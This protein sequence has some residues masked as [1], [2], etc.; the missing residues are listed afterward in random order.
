MFGKK[1]KRAITLIELVVVIA[2]IAILAGVS[3]TVFIGVTNKARTNADKEI[4]SQL[5]DK[6]RAKKI[7]EGSNKTAHDAY[8]DAKEIGF[9]LEAIKSQ[10]GGQYVWDETNDLFACVKL[11]E[12]GKTLGE[13]IAEDE[14][15]PFSSEKLEKAWIF[16]NEVK[17]DAQYSQY[18]NKACDKEE[19][20]VIAGF[21]GGE[22][23]HVKKVTYSGSEDVVIRTATFSTELNVQSGTVNHYGYSGIVKVNSGSLNE[24]GVVGRLL[25]S[26]SV[27]DTAKVFFKNGG[28]DPE[29]TC[30]HTSTKIIVDGFYVYEVCTNCGHALVD[31][32]DYNNEGSNVNVRVKDEIRPLA[33]YEV[34]EVK[35]EEEKNCISLKADSNALLDPVKFT[36]DKKAMTCDHNFGS[37]KVDAKCLEN[38]KNSHE[39][40]LCHLEYAEVIPQFGHKW[41]EP[42]YIWDFDEEHYQDAKCVALATCKHDSDHEISEKVQ[43]G[44]GIVYQQTKEA[45]CTEGSKGTLTATFKK[46]PFAGK[47]ASVPCD[48][49]V[50]AKGHTF[51]EQGECIVCHLSVKDVFESGEGTALDPYVIKKENF[52]DFS[53]YTNGTSTEDKFFELEDDVV[54]PEEQL[55]PIGTSSFPF[56]G[57]FDGN[58]KTVSNLSLEQP[59]YATDNSKKIRDFG[60]FGVVNGGTEDNPTVIKDLTLDVDVQGYSNI[61]GLVSRIECTEESGD[62]LYVSIKNVTINGSVESI[63][64]N[65]GGFCATVGSGMNQGRLAGRWTNCHVEFINCTNNATVKS[66]MAS[67]GILAVSG[68]GTLDC[69]GVDYQE[70]YYDLATES[71]YANPMKGQTFDTHGSLTFKNCVNKGD[72]QGKNCAGICAHVNH[73]DSIA[74]KLGDANPTG[75]SFTHEDCSNTGSF[76]SYVDPIT[77]ETTELECAYNLFLDYCDPSSSG[78]TQKDCQ[79]YLNCIGVV[80]GYERNWEEFNLEGLN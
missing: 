45:N 74:Y 43:V 13:V 40:S 32:V 11:S 61:G 29:A 1:I 4:V 78:R 3:V 38:G 30:D 23:E 16:V 75:P 59:E 25:G 53:K 24:S 57:T 41:G 67:A 21:D 77:L 46:G 72:I 60:L 66:K 36:G 49:V 26:A 7:V 71:T 12:D 27:K 44:N 68:A 17:G 80:D 37:K 2:I 63:G 42:T 28:S 62:S 70:S 5:N 33:T 47:T 65:A 20:N 15:N 35:V 14:N 6:M 69:K 79:I 51:N 56:E 52:K 9:D 34:S 64:W 22:N 31:L 48:N 19:I 58:G 8:L 54:L 39:C 55:T 18:L 50:P 73:A 76:S 10:S